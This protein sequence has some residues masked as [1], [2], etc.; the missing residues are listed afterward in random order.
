MILQSTLLTLLSL[1]FA[2]SNGGGSMT[3]AVPDVLRHHRADVVDPAWLS[4]RAALNSKGELLL[5]LFSDSTQQRLRA[6]LQANRNGSCQRIQLESEQEHF[7]PQAT[8]DDVVLHSSIIVTG[9]VAGSARGFYRGL[10]GTLVALRNVER[11]K[12]FGEI[13][14]QDVL[15]IF[16]P[17]GAI[18]TSQGAV[19]SQAL[20]GSAAVPAPGDRLIAFMYGAPID[21]ENS[22]LEVDLGRNL[23]VE[24]HTTQR[25]N[26]NTLSAVVGQD[27]DFDDIVR[28]VKTH[29]GIPPS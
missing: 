15:R 6:H 27:T 14:R 19:C 24:A 1:C 17:G 3:A 11:L 16:F 25:L 22:I 21:E 28:R 20:P 5:E 12:Q 2:L 8:L 9:T 29:E 23:L 13:S 10:P 26:P 18:N 4:E 7:R